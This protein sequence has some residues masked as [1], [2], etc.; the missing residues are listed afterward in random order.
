[1]VTCGCALGGLQSP[2]REVAQHCPEEP[3]ASGRTKET[4]L[5]TIHQSSRGFST[6]IGSVLW[7]AGLEWF[8][9]QGVAQAAWPTRYSLSSNFISDLGAVNCRNAPGLGY[10]CSPL[11]AFM[12]YSSMLLGI[13]TVAG[14]VLLVHHW[15]RNKATTLGLL[16]LVLFGVGKVIVGL[17]PEDQRLF[18]HALGSLGILFGNV[19]CLVFAAGL[20][21]TARPLALIFLCIGVVGVISFVLLLLPALMTVRGASERLADWPLPLWLAVLGARFILRLA[22]GP[23]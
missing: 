18:L 12:N 13:C 9:A 7:I 20:W 16:L 6:I 21:R 17:A 4:R 8:V 5:G 1:M 2:Q 11:H 10:V 23:S 3:V 22:H 19:G 15:P 14:V